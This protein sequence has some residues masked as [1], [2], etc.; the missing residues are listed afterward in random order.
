[1][2]SNGSILLDSFMLGPITLSRWTPT[3]SVDLLHTG[4][5][6]AGDT[7]RIEAFITD[8]SQDFDGDSS[9]LVWSG[10]PQ[11][12]TLSGEVISC[13]TWPAG[14]YDVTLT[15]TSG[16]GASDSTN[17]TLNLAAPSVPASEVSNNSGDNT[18]ARASEAESA[19][20]T[21]IDPII[22]ISVGGVILL[23]IIVLFVVRSR[24]GSPPQ[25]PIHVPGMPSQMQMGQ[26]GAPHSMAPQPQVP[27]PPP[28]GHQQGY[29]QYGGPPR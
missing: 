29:G 15:Y 12:V 9:T 19:G 27:P 10:G 5:G 16:S 1:M 2:S 6:I 14:I 7:C 4:A 24:G 11:D 26:Y 21:D 3:V 20:A 22:I 18:S 8:P 23:M 17:L 25:P 13:R 28:S